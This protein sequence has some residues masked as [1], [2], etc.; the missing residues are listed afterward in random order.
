MGF[1]WIFTTYQLVQDFFHRMEVCDFMETKSH[2]K[3][4]FFP[5]MIPQNLG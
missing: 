3:P 2:Q 5:G 1:L 4:P